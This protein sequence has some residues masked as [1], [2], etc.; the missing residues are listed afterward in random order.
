MS[1]ITFQIDELSSQLND[2]LTEYPELAD[3][4]Q[5]RH[6]VMEGETNLTDVVER[7]WQIECDAKGMMSAISERQAD[8]AARQTRLADRIN[9]M[10]RMLLLVMNRAQ[11]PK[12]ELTEIT[13][14]KRPGSTSVHIDDADAVPKQLCKV[15]YT[16]DKTAIKK[17]LEQDEMIPGATLVM[18]PETISVRTK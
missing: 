5:L 15:S 12:L 1:N 13:I 10:R 3:D 18:G 7:L 14:S 9:A 16:P 8:L 2:L 4:E 6:D 11:L 17:A